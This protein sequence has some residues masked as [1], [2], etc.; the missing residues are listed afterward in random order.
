M[1]GGRILISSFSIKKSLVFRPVFCG[2]ISARLWLSLFLYNRKCASLSATA[3][4]VALLS[5]RSCRCSADSPMIVR[6]NIC[7]FVLLES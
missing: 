3:G 2:K 4:L 7:W 1:S 5:H 6:L